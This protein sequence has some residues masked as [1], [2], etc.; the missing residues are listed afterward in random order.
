[1]IT[2]GDDTERG[3]EVMNSYSE[4]LNQFLIRDHPYKSVVQI[5]SLFENRP[6]KPPPPTLNGRSVANLGSRNTVSRCTKPERIK[7]TTV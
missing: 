7:R 1:M 5:F 4:I 2:Q 6:Q 3:N